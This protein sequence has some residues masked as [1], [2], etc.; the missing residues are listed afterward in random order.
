M[1]SVPTNRYNPLLPPSIDST[2]ARDGTAAI[3]HD[4]GPTSGPVELLTACQ[5][6]SPLQWAIGDFATVEIIVTIRI[7]AQG[8]ASNHTCAVNFSLDNA[9]TVPVPTA[10]PYNVKYYEPAGVTGGT[11]LTEITSHFTI[12]TLNNVSPGD[13]LYLSR[14]NTGGGHR[15]WYHVAGHTLVR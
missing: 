9:C 13:Q 1:S 2:S 4:N 5:L 12:N 15:V 6:I 3:R 11:I 7:V 8:S 14:V 10:Y